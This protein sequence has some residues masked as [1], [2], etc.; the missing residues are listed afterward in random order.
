MKDANQFN[1]GSAD[2]QGTA[3]QPVSPDRFDYG[4]Y[5]E[6]EARLLEGNRR[7][8]KAD[9]GVAVYR[10]FRVPQCFSWTCRD[11]EAS[12]AYQLG[13][14]AAS[15]AYKADVPNFLE[16]WY[17]IG[18][19]ASAFGADYLWPDLQAPVVPRVFRSVQE[20]LDRAATP[21]EHTA[22]GR[23]ALEMIEYFVEATHGR[24]PIS[25]T[26][27]Q[28]PLNALSFL[29]DT[30]AF[31]TG[32]LDAPDA[33]G[34][35]LDRLVPLQVAFVNAQRQ[36]LKECLVWPGHGFASTRAFS[37]LG[38]SDDIMTLL[39]PGQYRQFGVPRLTRCGE[40]FGGPA[41]HSCGNW[42]DKLDV[43]RAIRGLAM[44]DAAFTAQTDPS[45]NDP[46][47]F[48]EAFA[49]TGIVVN[50]RMVGSADTVLRCV[51]ALWRPGMRLIVVT[52]CQDPQEQA[53]VYEAVHKVCEE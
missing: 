4:A 21:V 39:S 1:T 20:A 48:A 50:A 22:I 45:P 15:L 7:F 36:R 13:A 10:R 52:Y 35:M 24:L 19:L 44:V 25:L 49:G 26:D 12:L 17:G 27:T 8:C 9:S 34:R 2:S 29:V 16:P 3:V 31:Y 5:A 23:H 30:G 43:V 47:R 14:L 28:S 32:F 42:A 6:Y 51:R 18:T 38:M 53:Q 37:G 33:L 40:P 41:V 11:Q 46:A